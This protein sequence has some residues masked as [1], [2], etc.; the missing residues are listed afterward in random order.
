[1]THTDTHTYTRT[2]AP[3]SLSS[4]LQKIG[5]FFADIQESRGGGEGVLSKHM[6]FRLFLLFVF[7]F[8]SILLFFFFLFLFPI[9]YVVGF[10]VVLTLETT[11]SLVDEGRGSVSRGSVS[12]IQP[13]NQSFD[14]DWFTPITRNCVINTCLQQYLSET[15]V[16]DVILIA[17][18]S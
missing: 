1:M 4:L 17:M 7:C 18:N 6:T 13:M 10:S 15:R 14:T 8:L 5:P 9:L 11:V 3:P 16:H 2:Q 12:V